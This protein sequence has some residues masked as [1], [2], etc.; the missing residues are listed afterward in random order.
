MDLCKD[1]D[2]RSMLT[3]NNG[4]L[5]ETLSTQIIYQILKGMMQLNEQ[6][7]AHRDIKPENIFIHKNVYKIADFGF[8]ERYKNKKSMNFYGGTPGYSSP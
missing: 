5:D 4:R 3:K 2:L 8:C 6:R 1:G 7:I